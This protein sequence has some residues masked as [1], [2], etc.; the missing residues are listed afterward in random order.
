MDSIKKSQNYSHQCLTC[1][2]QKISSLHG[3]IFHRHFH[4]HRYGT[5]VPKKKHLVY[6][7]IYENKNGNLFTKGTTH[8]E[9]N[10]NT[11]K[12][13]QE[14][15]NNNNEV[16]DIMLKGHPLS[17]ISYQWRCTSW[18]VRK[19]WKTATK[20][21]SPLKNQGGLHT[22][23]NY[24]HLLPIMRY[25]HWRYLRGLLMMSYTSIYT[26]SQKGCLHW[27]TLLHILTGYNNFYLIFWTYSM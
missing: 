10:I 16:E 9:T 17:Q 7:Y 24:W 4:F 1:C 15:Q 6:T 8:V 22:L 12:E 2:P 5:V 18:Y 27:H 23:S 21:D 26:R 14:H 25:K 13:N 19:R 3:F 11:W 20:C